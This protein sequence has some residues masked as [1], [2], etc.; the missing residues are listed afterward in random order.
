MIGQGH[1]VVAADQSV[2]SEVA[3]EK[4]LGDDDAVALA[5]LDVHGLGGAQSAVLGARG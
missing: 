1:L 3:R 2:G 4:A 5:E